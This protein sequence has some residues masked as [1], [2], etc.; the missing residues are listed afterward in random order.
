[1][2][3]GIISNVGCSHG[4]IALLLLLLGVSF[5]EHSSSFAWRAKVVEVAEIKGR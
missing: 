4:A 3:S 1:M 2:D 5:N